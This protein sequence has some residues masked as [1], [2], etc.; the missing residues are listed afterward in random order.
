MARDQHTAQGVLEL[1]PKGYGFLRD[2][3]RNYTAQ[4]SDPYVPGPLIQKHHLREGLLL[5]GPLE[6][7]R[8]GTGPRLA[9]VDQVEGAP[10]EQYVRRNFD[11]D[12]FA[13]NQLD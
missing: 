1:H 10:P 8:K 13:T 3:A 11:V 4:Q 9:R 2:P 7:A 6:A 12:R 5:T